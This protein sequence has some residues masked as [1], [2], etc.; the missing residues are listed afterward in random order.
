VVVNV[1]VT[2]PTTAGNLRFYPAGL[3]VPPTSALNYAAAQTRANN[4]TLALGSAGALD[5][6]CSQAWGT[7]HVI[8]DVT[9]YYE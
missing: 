2:E 3:P 4:A 6:L 1:T 5:A 8:V 9:G 7:A